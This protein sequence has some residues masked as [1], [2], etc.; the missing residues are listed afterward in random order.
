MKILKTYPDGSQTILYEVGDRVVLKEVPYH[1]RW[2]AS[3]GEHAI[4]GAWWHRSP[5][6]PIDFLEVRTDAMVRGKWGALKVAP[7]DVEP[8]TTEMADPRV[9]EAEGD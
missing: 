7:W 9:T 4:V 8:V 3:P 1:A 2:L 5:K 6:S